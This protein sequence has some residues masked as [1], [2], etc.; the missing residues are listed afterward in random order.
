M[1]KLGLKKYQNV[2]IGK[3]INV[4]IRHK[5]NGKLSCENS[6]GAVGTFY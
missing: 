6:L 3:F 1:S 5:D 4:G 2:E